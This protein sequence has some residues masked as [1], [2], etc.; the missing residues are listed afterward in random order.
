LPASARQ[1]LATASEF[2]TLAALAVKQVLAGTDRRPGRGGEDA[3]TR[4]QAGR[5]ARRAGEGR[6][7]QH[8]AHARAAIAPG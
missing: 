4:G 1:A 2:G 8:G 5:A 6:A 3:P 7:P